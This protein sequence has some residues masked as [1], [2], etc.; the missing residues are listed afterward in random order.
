MIS[1]RPDA[2]HNRGRIQAGGGTVSPPP[3]TSPL[4]IL[5]SA[6][7]WFRGDLG[8]TIGTGVSSWADQSGNGVNATEGVGASQPAF[9]ASDIDGRPAVVGDGV[10]D[11]LTMTW[12]RGA[13]GTT[14]CYIWMVACQKT[15]T[16][17]D[18]LLGD[19]SGAGNGAAIQT[20][21]TTPTVRTLQNGANVNGAMTVGSY[22]RVEWQLAGGAG[23]YLKIG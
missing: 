22:F 2:R 14:P 11:N 15:W 16:I 19:Y 18:F 6:A 7:W 5:G 4:T 8:V 13:P 12:A 21:G 20:S 3:P 23:D 9:L 17:F 10:D 1:R